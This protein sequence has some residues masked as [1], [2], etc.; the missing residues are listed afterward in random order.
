MT[1]ETGL[2]L[3]LTL[4]QRAR[5][6][7]FYYLYAFFNSF[8]WAS[9]AEG[10][11]ILLLLRLGASE[12]WVGIVAALQYV[13]LP[14]MV[15]GYVTVARLGVTGTAGLFWAIRSC[16]AALMIIAPWTQRWGVHMPLWFMFCGSLGFMLGRAS[17]LVAFT[18]IIT[19]L[20]TDRDRGEVISNSSKI[21]QFGSIL[22]TI[23]MALFLGTAAP[24][25]RYQILL[26]FGMLCGLTAAAAL[27]K[28]PES[29][30]F[31]QTTP[32]RLWEE[33]RWSLATRG[34]RWFMA[35]MLGLPVTQGVTYAFG[36]LVAKQG[37]GLSDQNVVFFVLVATVGG[38]VA[39]HT[40]SLFLD[41]LGSRPLLVLT[42]FLDIGGVVLV[43]FLPPTFMFVLVGA[44]FFVNGYVQIAFSAAMQHYFIS[45][46]THAHQLAHGIITRALG[47]MVGGLALGLGGWALERVKL[48]STATADP[49][50]H[51]RWFYAGLLLLLIIRTVV[52]FKLPPL[53]S[54]GIRDALNALFSPWDWRAVHAVKRAITVQSEDEESKALAALMHT[55]SRIYQAD[56]ERY[57]NSPSIFIRQ[58]AMD[59]LQRAKPTPTLIAILERDLQ[60]NRF[61]TA[62]QAAYWLG[63]W[64]VVEAVPLLAKAVDS[65]DFL[66]SGAAIHALAGLDERST[67]P[68]IE[69]KFSQT[70]N[71]YVLIEGAR[72]ISLWGQPRRY[73]LLL[74]KYL[75]DIPPQA[76]DELSLS[77]TRL[78]GLYDAFYFDLGMRH[79]EPAQLM[80]EWQERYAARDEAGL[81][82]AL[83][84][85][86]PQRALLEASL[87]AQQRRFQLWFY[88]D[89]VDFLAKLTDRVHGEVAFLMAFLLLTPDGFHIDS[90]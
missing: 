60:V 45:I 33:L 26:A 59:A 17:G 63:H 2:D 50:L 78:L 5:G 87:Q 81:I 66:L 20:T 52:F 71:P 56:L 41:Q 25:H 85:G 72:A 80:R 46:T 13:T 24:L 38:I 35:M 51:F 74:Q 36:V 58:R 43:I 68:L 88:V 22:M 32:F 6:K 16:S 21:S 62:H 39:S 37:Y 27:W 86:D 70:Q 53:R 4:K 9:L 19:E 18:G 75:L 65:E 23:G 15:L 14:A 40:Y 42:S 8:S 69:R 89:T 76:K 55:D 77:I 64:K 28:V 34:R 48:A 30:L 11:V 10:V 79:R 54:Q 84:R 29:G 57:L 3:S 7:R 83:H 49:L 90:H 31:R 12:T 61:T 82:P 67:L 1:T 73:G 44:L 47:G